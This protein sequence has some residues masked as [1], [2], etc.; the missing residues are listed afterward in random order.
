MGLC[1][2]VETSRWQRG[3]CLSADIIISLNTLGDRGKS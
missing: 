2:D 1:F 3:L